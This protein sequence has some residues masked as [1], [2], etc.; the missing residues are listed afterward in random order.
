MKVRMLKSETGRLK[1]GTPAQHFLAGSEYDVPKD[2]GDKWISIGLA[3]KIRAK[4]TTGE[5]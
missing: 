4:R 5:G 2:V 3:E 1:P